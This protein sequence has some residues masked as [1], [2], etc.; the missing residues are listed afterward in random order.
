VGVKFFGQ[1]LIDSGEVDA[2]HV[3]EA[4]ELMD[5]ENLPLGQIAVA[6]GFMQEP[7]VARVNAEQRNRDLS[8][9][10]LA[11]SMGLLENT[12]LVHAL[13]IQSSRR[14]P[15]GQ[16]LVRLEHIAGD[17]LGIL[18]DAYK[19]DQAQYDVGTIELPDGLVSH[20]VSRYVIELFPRFMLRIARMQVK[21]GE[22]HSFDETPDFAEIRVSVPITGTRGVEVALVCD[23]VF[24][25]SLAQA[26]SGLDPADLDAEM[27]ADGVGEF[28]NVLCGNA[29]S[30]VAKEGYPVELGPPD[31]GA[32]LCDG[33]SV[34][35]AV[36]VGRAV[37]I[38]S[39]F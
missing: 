29:A 25:E 37:L 4:L 28:L 2:S 23:L 24:G 35:L 5:S 9:G 11:V 36:G 6:E 27:V 31:Y 26:A 32:E 39:T 10:D 15:I 30:A 13:Q 22:I 33:W 3:S 16:A 20:R 34:E 38:L 19:T 7:Q 12:Q 1:F 8:F 21:I 18:L 17:R 14:L